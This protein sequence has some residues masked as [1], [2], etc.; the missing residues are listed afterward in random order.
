MCRPAVQRDPVHWLPQVMGAGQDGAGGAGLRGRRLGQ[1]PLVPG[2]RWPRAAA[3]PVGGA[4]PEPDAG[5]AQP[6]QHRVRVQARHGRQVPVCGPARHPGAGLPAAGDARHQ[7]VRVL[8]SGRRAAPRRVAQGRPPVLGARH[9][10]GM[11]KGFME[12]F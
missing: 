4:P 1:P 2:G 8:L 3:A 5:A 6:A 11:R 12:N 10:S 9:N 7:H